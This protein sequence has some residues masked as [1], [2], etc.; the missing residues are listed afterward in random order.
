MMVKTEKTIQGAMKAARKALG[1]EAEEGRDFLI[2]N[3]GAGYAFE[4]KAA[5]PDKPGPKKRGTPGTST[6]N[7]PAKGAPKP[8]KPVLRDLATKAAEAALG[9]IPK[10]RTKKPPKAAARPAVTIGRGDAYIRDTKIGEVVNVTAPQGPHSAAKADTKAAHVIALLARPDGATVAQI[11]EATGWL[12]HSARAFITA[13]VPKRGFDVAS[14]KDMAG[15]PPGVRV[16]RATERGAPQNPAAGIEPQ[17]EQP[18]AVV[19]GNDVV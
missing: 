4:A 17:P 2:V 12:A 14:T 11:M 1:A 19:D 13:T 6:V 3:T 15:D 9:P 10:I 5:A 7:E 8:K 18:A 16:Y